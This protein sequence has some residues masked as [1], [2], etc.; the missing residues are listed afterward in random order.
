M[1]VTHDA[2]PFRFIVK[3]N[4]KYYLTHELWEF[5]PGNPPKDLDGNQK[6]SMDQ[7]QGAYHGGTQTQGA[8]EVDS[9]RAVAFTEITRLKSSPRP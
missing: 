7:I 1:S 5:D 2:P 6:T 9:G 8:A 4:E 3:H